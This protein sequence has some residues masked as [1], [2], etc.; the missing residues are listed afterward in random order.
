[1]F[2][3]SGQNEFK[4]TAQDS[5]I[6]QQTTITANSPG[7]ILQ[8]F[9]TLLGYIQETKPSATKKHQLSLKDLEPLNQQM[10]RPFSHGL[11]RPQQ[12]SFPHINGLYLLLR[13][14]GFAHFQGTKTKP[15]LLLEEVVL[16]SWQAL[17]TTER[18]CTLL[19]SWLLRGTGELIGERYGRYSI[20]HNPLSEWIQLH[21][22]LATMDIDNLREPLTETMRYFP[23]HHNLALLEMFGLM[24]VESKE[25]GPGE[26][27][28][29]TAV[30]PT[31]FGIA[32]MRYL[33]QK[34]YG[35]DQWVF[36]YDNPAQI[37]PGQLQAVLQPY[38]PDWQKNLQWPQSTFRPGTHT[39]LVSL[40]KSIW[41]RIAI[42]ADDYLEEL[43]YA[44]LQAFKFDDD[45]LYRFIYPNHLGT[46]EHVNHPWL[47]EG[48][49]TDEVRVGDVPLEVGG[50]MW[51]NFDFGD[52]WYFELKLERVEGGDEEL[53]GPKILESHGKAPEQYPSYDDEW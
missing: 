24:A 52:N 27:W 42:A 14:S 39:F 6:L 22:R 40:S 47:D 41:R 33:M 29:I 35:N 4:F 1:M 26:G 17:D 44:I 2:D 49:F 7:T 11:K 37:T 18:Y 51:F 46:E 31:R 48:P 45:H 5:N 38:F 16:S 28:Q 25:P 15:K 23:G 32:L 3:L 43:V 12:K 21:R 30:E 20:F 36:K 8:D 19:E 9:Q 34:I 50:M 13:A 10:T 53:Q